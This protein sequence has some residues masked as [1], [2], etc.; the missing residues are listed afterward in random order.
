[1][2]IFVEEAAETVASADAQVRDGGR[3]GDRLGER[4]QRSGIRY[5]PVRPVRVVVRFVLAEGV[6]Q[7]GLVP[8]QRAVE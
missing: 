2:F 8:D 5:A 1:M 6:E 7:V 3:V 4:V